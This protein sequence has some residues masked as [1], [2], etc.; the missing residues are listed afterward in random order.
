MKRK[1]VFRKTTAILLAAACILSGC[2][3]TGKGAAATSPAETAAAGNEGGPAGDG[4]Q[5][6]QESESGAPEK[7][8]EGSPA[9]EQTVRVNIESEPMTLNSIQAY[10]LVSFNV[11]RHIEEGLTKL[12]DNNEVIP[13]IAESWDVSDDLL[14]YTFHLREAKW[15]NGQPVTA[16]DFAFGWKTVLDGQVGAMFSYLMFDIKNAQAFNA[17]EAGEEELGIKVIDEKTLEVT[18][19]RPIPYFPFLCSQVSFLPV[20][21]A[22]Y[23]E[24]T[25]ESADLYGS[26]GDKL[27]CNGAFVIEGWNHESDIQLKKNPDYYEASE[28]KLDN[29][30]MSMVSDGSTAYNMFVAGE[31]DTVSL[32]TGDQMKQAEL[33]GYE[34]LSKSN[35]ATGYLEFNTRDEVLCNENIRKALAYSIDRKSLIE[36]VLKDASRPAL[37]FTNPDISADDGSSFQAQVG[38]VVLDNDSEKAKEL[39]N[40]GME[41]L[42]LS[43]APKITLTIDDRDT[44][45]LKAAAFQEFW[46]QNLGVEVEVESMPYKSKLEKIGSGDFQI[47]ISSWGPDYNDAMSFLDLYVSTSTMSEAGYA[48]QEYDSL[49]GQAKDETDR[50]KRND[51]MVQAEKLLMEELPLAPVEFQYQAYAVSPR[52]KGLYRSSFQDMDLIHAYLEE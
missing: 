19:E 20:N 18:L 52:L 27:L 49:I 23:E 21:Q 22:F 39:F 4:S 9:G 28:V 40:L 51:L 32:N 1:I 44:V 37:S 3:T 48:S 10:D 46:R 36:N 11:L 17:G 12:D 41:E 29:I 14:T 7:D 31:L 47:G 8:G 2:S 26:D 25:A 24:V 6:A 43:Q 45:R 16:D 30:Q 15:S 38:D 5:A 35:G 13:G 42:G 34:V 33:D 50:K